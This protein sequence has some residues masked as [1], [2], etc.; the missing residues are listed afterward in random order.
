MKWKLFVVGVVIGAVGAF[1]TMIYAQNN[2]PL[3]NI[4]FAPKDFMDEGDMRVGISGTLTGPGTAPNNTNAI[5]C[6]KERMECSISSV[7]Q[8][9]PDQIARMAYAYNVPI[10]KWDASEV[11]AVDDVTCWKTTITIDRKLK[12]SVWVKEPT[13]QT[14][15]RCKDVDTQVRKYSIDDSPRWKEMIHDAPH[16]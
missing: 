3:E 12:T 8:I 15:P 13:N 11:V 1:G 9:G 10:K 14:Q 5:T 16:N 4:I 2:K 6:V 7:A